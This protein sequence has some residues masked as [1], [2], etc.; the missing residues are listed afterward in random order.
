M[1]QTIRLTESKLRGLIN[2][3]V[4][5][6]LYTKRRTKNVNEAKYNK[7]ADIAWKK[8]ERIAAELNHMQS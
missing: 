7:Q 6:C 5:N 4:K 1:K 3:A 2:E 8:I